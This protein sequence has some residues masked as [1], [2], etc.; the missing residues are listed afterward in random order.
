VIE[1][2][3]QHRQIFKSGPLSGIC[4]E[5]LIVSDEGTHGDSDDI[6]LNT[7]DCS[8]GSLVAN[9]SACKPR[10]N[11]R[12][13]VTERHVIKYDHQLGHFLFNDRQT[14]AVVGGLKKSPPPNTYVAC[15]CT[16]ELSDNLF[17]YSYALTAAAEE[18]GLH[19]NQL[20]SVQA[21]L[22]GADF[23]SAPLSLVTDYKGSGFADKPQ[24]KI[25][26]MHCHSTQRYLFVVYSQGQV[27]VG[28]GL[29]S[30]LKLP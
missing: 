7:V 8:S 12:V 2:M 5:H 21:V 13:V 11:L 29:A 15:T 6:L 25:V 30:V 17:F 10:R 26:S 18:A 19:S 16:T 24:G 4:G 14:G 22:A 23:V 20:H 9:L 3:L 1:K 27:Q 28:S